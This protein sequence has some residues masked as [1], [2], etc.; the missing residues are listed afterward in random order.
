MY[1]LSFRFFSQELSNEIKHHIPKKHGNF[2][3]VSVPYGMDPFYLF[4]LFIWYVQKCFGSQE[5]NRKQ[6]RT[7]LNRAKKKVTQF[8]KYTHALLL[9]K[10][11]LKKKQAKRSSILLVIYSSSKWRNIASFHFRMG[12]SVFGY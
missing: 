7:S 3:K 4:I 6:Q 10:L 2:Q 1:A 5:Y 11:A 8:C 12:V 9:T